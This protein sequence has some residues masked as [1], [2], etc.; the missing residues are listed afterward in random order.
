MLV[1]S[2]INI[3]GI[4]DAGG[5][6]ALVKFKTKCITPGKDIQVDRAAFFDKQSR[7][8]STIILTSVSRQ[9]ALP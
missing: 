7:A 1:V 2:L 8:A 4:A 6:I 9:A 5:Q 3:A